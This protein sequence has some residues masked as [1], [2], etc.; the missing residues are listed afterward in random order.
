MKQLPRH[1]RAFQKEYPGIAA[2]Y[3]QLG[4]VVHGGG[5]LDAHTRALV[6]CALAIGAGLEGGT[7]AQVR[8]ALAAGVP[9]EELR[10]IAL[11]AI[12]TVGFPSAMAALSWIDD[13]A[14]PRGSRKPARRR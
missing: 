10:Q 5:P 7:H 13:L 1:Y 4:A 2:A 11:L 3:E 14:G 6:K 12:T 9:A 8:K